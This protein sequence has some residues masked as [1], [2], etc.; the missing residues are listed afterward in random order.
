MNPRRS[1]RPRHQAPQPPQQRER[2]QIETRLSGAPPMEF[3]NK[4]AWDA[5]DTTPLGQEVRAYAERW[6]RLMQLELGRGKKLR[7]IWEKTSYEADFTGMSAGGFGMAVA[8]LGQGWK[9]GNELVGFYNA[10]RGR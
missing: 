2:R 1:R 7:S 6:A 8:L 5:A 3:S 9:H 4:A 10:A